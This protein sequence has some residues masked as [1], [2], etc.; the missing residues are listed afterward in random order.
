MF[1][2]NS[3]ESDESDAL[4]SA[5]IGGTVYEQMPERDPCFAHS[6]QLVVKDGIGAAERQ[7]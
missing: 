1:L 5:F 3:L 4:D 2:G 6:L 7:N